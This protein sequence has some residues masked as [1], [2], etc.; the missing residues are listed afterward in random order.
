MGMFSAVSLDVDDRCGCSSSVAGASS[1]QLFI[2]GNLP[3]IRKFDNCSMNRFVCAHYFRTSVHAKFCASDN[4][5]LQM[6]DGVSELCG[7]QPFAIATYNIILHKNDNSSLFYFKKQQLTR[8]S[9][10]RSSHDTV[11]L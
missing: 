5:L 8:S 4:C 9:P 2:E 11:S 1:E 3:S 6:T 7:P 10:G